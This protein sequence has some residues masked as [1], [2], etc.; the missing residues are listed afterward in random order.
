MNIFIP[1]LF[2]CLAEHCEFMQQ[3]T[4]YK[5]DETCREEVQRKKDE[6]EKMTGKLGAKIEATCIEANVSTKEREA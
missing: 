5:S 3:K 6:M 4:Y 1:V 2:V